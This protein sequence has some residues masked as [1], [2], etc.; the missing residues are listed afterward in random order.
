MTRARHLTPDE[1]AVFRD[2]LRR[3][4]RLVAKGAP[5]SEVGEAGQMMTDQQIADRVQAAAVALNTA[6]TEAHL[7]GL[8]VEVDR[9]QV[10]GLGDAVPR[11]SLAVSL[12]RRVV[13]S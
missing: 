1:Q 11:V 13:G 6:L 5:V 12:Y 7:H 2:A 4:G 8:M 9:D 10:I 3:S